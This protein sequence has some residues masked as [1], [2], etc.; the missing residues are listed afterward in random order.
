MFTSLLV[1]VLGLFFKVG[2]FFLTGVRGGLSRGPTI[3][4]SKPHRVYF[5]VLGLIVFIK[6]LLLLLK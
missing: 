5:V 1:A 4:A 3:P 2:S 6:G